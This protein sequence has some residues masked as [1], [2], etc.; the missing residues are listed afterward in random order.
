M[1]ITSAAVEKLKEFMEDFDAPYPRV[2]MITGGSSCNMKISLGVT[3]DDEIN[4][5]DVV[6]ELEG[7]S[8]LADKSFYA[9][10]GDKISID[11][12][13]GQGIVAAILP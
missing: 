1:Q 8:I 12:V 4:D 11:F 10:H 5:N 13:P 3:L 6:I 7:L 2:G 9:R